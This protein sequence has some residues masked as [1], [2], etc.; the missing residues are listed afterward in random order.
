[1]IKPK[2]NYERILELYKNGKYSEINMIYDL[3]KNDFKSNT[4]ILNI[5]GI[6]LI[7]EKSYDKAIDVFEKIAAINP[8]DNNVKI[9]LG[10][11]YRLTGQFELA[12]KFFDNYQKTNKKSYQVYYN[13]AL[14][15]IELGNNELAKKNFSLSLDCAPSDDTNLINQICEY[16]IKTLIDSGQNDTAFEVCNHLIIK[17]PKSYILYW[18]LANLST[19]SNKE[20][21]AQN[22]YKKAMDIEPYNQA[23]KFDFAIW[24]KKNGKNN[25][26]I[27]I[28]KGLDLSQARAHYIL[29]L[30][31]LGKNSEFQEQLTKACF[32]Y[33]GNRLVANLSKYVSYL[34]NQ[35][36]QYPFCEDPFSFIYTNN[37]GNEEL[38]NNVLYKIDSIALN[39]TNQ[40]LL[41]NGFQSS[42]NLFQI[43]SSEI[44]QLKEIIL[45]EIG[46]YKSHF[47]QGNEYFIENWPKNST[48]KSWYINLKEGGT[49]DYHIHPDGWV[50]GTVY[51]EVPKTENDIEGSIQFGF[52]NANYK[53]LEGLPTKTFKPKRSDIVIFPSSLSHRVNPF[54]D[55]KNDSR[56]VSLA[57]D[58]I[59]T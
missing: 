43:E 9:N 52:N 12:L 33:K 51:L 57:F 40:K 19:W 30:F 47:S 13:L 16:Y 35:V 45:N 36:D 5:L 54:Q 46:I 44:N 14:T 41:K 38:L 17:F 58:L 23:L 6:S 4:K 59:P 15:H 21:K 20:E 49:L 8:K 39:S 1:M 34:N 42:G 29:T 10:N 2:K 22:F 3:S 25:D 55:K 11:L 28:L 7:H 48:L 56:R 32:D 24:C 26:A 31:Q 18:R 50:S 27:E 37:I 53:F